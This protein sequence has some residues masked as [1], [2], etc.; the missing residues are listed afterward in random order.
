[1]PNY[2]N[3]SLKSFSSG[4]WSIVLLSANVYT[5][6]A[7][8]TFK[9]DETKWIS[10][11]AGMQPVLKLRKRRCLSG[12]WSNDFTLDNIR[13]Y[14]NGQVHQYVVEV[15][16]ECPSCSNGGDMQILD[17]I[18]KFEFDPKLNVWIGRM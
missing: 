12:K 1:M 17:A 7:S 18:G 10:I 14:L 16:T 5:V 6:Q 9:L 15:N 8:P 13:L 4:L 2:L 11:G 3:F